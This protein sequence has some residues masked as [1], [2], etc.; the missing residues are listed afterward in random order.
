MTLALDGSVVGAGEPASSVALTL[1]TVNAGDI[2]IVFLESFNG[3]PTLSV[4][5][6]AGLTWTKRQ[7]VDTSGTG[8]NTTSIVEEWWALAPS[9]LSSDVITITMSGD[10]F[11]I[12]YAFAISGANTTSPF[13]TNAAVPASNN[14]GGFASI[15]TTAANTFV[16]A[17]NRH[18]SLSSFSAG[19]GFTLVATPIGFGD[20]AQYAIFSSAQ[21]GLSVADSSPSTVIVSIADAIVAASGG[22]GTTHNQ[23]VSLTS[24]ASVAILKSTG[25]SVALTST[26]A[27]SLARACGKHIA[28]ASVAAVS[29]ARQT[30][31]G[32]AIAS[33]AALSVSK[34]CAKAIGLASVAAVS[35]SKA[36]AKHVALTSVAALVVS[37]IK[38]HV[39][40]ISITSS[41]A[42]SMSRQTGKIVALASTAA[43]SL[44]K[45][46]AKTVSLISTAIIS[47]GFPPAG[48]V[49]P[50]THDPGPIDQRI[51]DWWRR[52][53]QEVYDRDH[54]KPVIAAPKIEIAPPAPYAP[55]I[56]HPEDDD[57]NAIVA[58]LEAP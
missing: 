5:D 2:I 9:A 34:A 56:Y 55:P 7:S 8:G 36:V 17:Y 6:T 41:A 39:V 21:T 43:L 40:L 49:A 58:L 53:R 27:V 24:A 18:S 50:D 35:V 52:K 31:K 1:S 32:I 23:G 38:V 15:S 44:A 10:Q 25:K 29:M 48:G 13:D 51:I 28:L 45:A 22:G 19:S 42:V 12:G 37:A 4:A 16:I 14:V 47:T 46:I 3:G 11:L 33:S 20:L 26:G 54:P 30:H 57:V